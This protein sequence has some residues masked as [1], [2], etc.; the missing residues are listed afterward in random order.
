MELKKI[1]KISVIGLFLLSFLTHSLYNWLPNGLF[2]IFFPVNESIWEH[3]KML[4]TTILLYSI[5][6]YF[7]LKRFHIEFHNYLLSIFV[8]AICSIIIY[9]GL[10]LPFYYHGFHHMLFYLLIMFIT[11]IICSYI[12]YVIMIQKKVSYQSIISII[13]II[14]VYIIFG[15][16]TYYPL[17]NDLFLD[18]EEEKYGLHDYII[19]NK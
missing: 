1:K 13:A 18:T 14:I 6:E 10:F 12:S 8:S 17:K 16:L 3:M 7:L 9:L 5:I 2:S 4:Y 19:M 15:Y 11:Y